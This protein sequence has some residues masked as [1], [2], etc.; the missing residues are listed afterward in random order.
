[1][2]DS[3]KN[4]DHAVIR[5]PIGPQLWR[6]LSVLLALML[7]SLFPLFFFPVFDGSTVPFFALDGPLATLAWWL[8][9]SGS[10]YGL[11]IVIAALLVLF[12][13]RPGGRLASRVREIL[14]LA[15]ALGVL[16]GGSA[17]LNE[18]VVKPAVAAPRPDIV[19]LAGDGILGMTPAAFYRLGDKA[20]RSQYLDQVLTAAPV[21]QDLSP[22][23]RD[24]WIKETGYSFPSGHSLSSML[25]ATAFVGLA[26]LLLPPSRRRWVSVL[27]PW[28]LAVCYSRAILRV[29]SPFDIVTGAVI[30]MLL[31]VVTFLLMRWVLTQVCPLGSPSCIRPGPPG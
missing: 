17:W 24:H 27:I 7:L 23:V 31:G 25:V 12:A 1:M 19:L 29:H 10:K 18:H 4:P 5:G 15:L 30:G 22:A 16:V 3:E 20:A 2:T 14:T 11:P 28:A 6:R 26:L 13:T 21:S 8:S 9:L